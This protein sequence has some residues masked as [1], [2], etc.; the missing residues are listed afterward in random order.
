M[1]YRD[2]DLQAA[3]EQSA[4][5]RAACQLVDRLIELIGRR[6]R[7]GQDCTSA[8]RAQM[9]ALLHRNALVA[10]ALALG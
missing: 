2:P 9:A 1:Q 8:I 3:Y 5:V 10:K 4:E 7:A 6:D